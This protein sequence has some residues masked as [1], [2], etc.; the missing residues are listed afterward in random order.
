MLV[1]NLLPERPGEALGLSRLPVGRGVGVR[2]RFPDGIPDR[3][4]HCFWLLQ[5]V[6]VPESQDSP[7]LCFQVPAPGR[8]DMVVV[9]RAIQLHDQLLRHTTKV[10]DVWRNR[11]LAPELQTIQLRSEEHT[12]ELQSLMRISYAVFCLKTKKK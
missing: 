1:W 12:S 8:I 3:V 6:V 5:R 11:V 10:G 7:A 9:L 2:V 4:D